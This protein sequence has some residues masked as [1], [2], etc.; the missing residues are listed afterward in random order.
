MLEICAAA[1]LHAQKISLLG[2]AVCDIQID[3][4]FYAVI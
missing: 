4:I 1:V 3:G 2:K